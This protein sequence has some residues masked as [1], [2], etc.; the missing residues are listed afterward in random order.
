MFLLED[1]LLSGNGDTDL[2]PLP[3]VPQDLTRRPSRTSNLLCPR[4]HKKMR[5]QNTFYA[6][7]L[8]YNYLYQALNLMT[9]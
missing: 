2:L 7:P 1:V 5:T 6:I 9:D 8:L 4:L 3:K